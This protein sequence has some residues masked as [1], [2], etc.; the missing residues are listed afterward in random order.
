MLLTLRSGERE[1]YPSTWS[2]PGGHLESGKLEPEALRREPREELGIDVRG[3]DDEPTSRLHHTTGGPSAEL[4]LSTW[5]IRTWRGQ[6]RSV[7]RE[8]HDRIAW[9]GPSELEGLRW[10]H[11][12]HRQMLQGMLSRAPD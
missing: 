5:R 10:A 11:P 3:C 8:E 1:A 7:L 2:L 6:P 4:H 9:L 12:Q